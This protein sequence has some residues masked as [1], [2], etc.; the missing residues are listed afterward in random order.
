MTLPPA[1]A[2]TIA[3][4]LKD[5]DCTPSDF[6]AIITGDLGFVGSD[7]LLE[8]IEREYGVDISAVHQDCGKLIYDREGQKVNAGGSGCGCSASVMC[9]HF[10]D[11]LLSGEMNQ[12]MFVATGALLSPVT[13]KQSESIPSVAH[14]VIIRRRDIG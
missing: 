5:L 9:A 4:F 3:E 14:G 12:I 1:A 6:N 13:V 11:K 2:S 7:I 8:F 10:M